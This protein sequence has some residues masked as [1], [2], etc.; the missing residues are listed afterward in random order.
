VEF[1]VVG[2]GEAGL[3]AELLEHID[4]TYFRPH[5]VTEEAVRLIATRTGQDIHAILVDGDR[6]VAYGLL[7]GW[8]EGFDTPSLGIAV[9]DELQGQGLG[10]VMM[11]HLH[12]AARARGAS[13][14]R[15]RVHADN[16][17]ARSL[18]EA[19]G[20]EYRGDDRGELLMI[21]EFDRGRPR[22]RRARLTSR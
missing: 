18:Y 20:Y 8:D 4:P 9:R 19:L 1:R 6:A 15:L 22:V 17:R 21:L 10:H 11:A 5:A 2:P 12:V 13:Q 3:L 16:L 14:I 7:R